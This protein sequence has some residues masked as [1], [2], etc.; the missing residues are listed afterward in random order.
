MSYRRNPTCGTEVTRP[1]PPHRHAPVRLWP[2]HHIQ[3]AQNL[4]GMI[5]QLR[6]R[7]WRSLFTVGRENGAVDGRQL[8]VPRVFHVHESAAG[9]HLWVFDHLVR[10]GR[11]AH[12]MSDCLNST[13]HSSRSRDSNWPCK[14]AKRAE[15]FSPLASL[16]ANSGLVAS[17]AWRGP[18]TDWEIPCRGPAEWPGRPCRHDSDSLPP[19]GSAVCRRRRVPETWRCRIWPEGRRR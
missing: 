16:V 14:M 17:S 3:V 2:P 9:P 7:A 5:A 18:C 12:L 8:A 4:A 15:A 13:R 11:G 10:T 19:M 1:L 6:G